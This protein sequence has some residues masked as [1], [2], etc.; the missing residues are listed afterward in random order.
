MVSTN[1]RIIQIQAS[2]SAPG[3]YEAVSEGEKIEKSTKD[4]K[5][6]FIFE[7]PYLVDG[8]NLIATNRYEI[9]KDNF[10][11]IEVY[12]YFFVRI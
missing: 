9:I 1:R 10:N 11:N 3:G 7:F 8:I 2:S 5:T 6:E 4:G 12:A